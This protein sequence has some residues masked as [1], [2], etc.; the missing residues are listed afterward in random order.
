MPTDEEFIGLLR[1]ALGHLYDSDRL[2]QSP[3]AR[4]FGVADQPDTAEALRRILIDAVESLRPPEES[5]SRSRD[6]RLYEAL[7]YQY[8]QQLDQRIVADQLALSVRHLRREQRAALEV[9]SDRLS[10]RVDACADAYADSRKDRLVGVGDLTAQD[11]PDLYP[12][13]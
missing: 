1:E 2:R 9:L 5:P 4:L 8:V 11:G 10:G 3:L 12:G 6:W 7:F 13:R